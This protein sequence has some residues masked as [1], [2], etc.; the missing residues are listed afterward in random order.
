MDKI[1]SGHTGN[2]FLKQLTFVTSS[3]MVV[4]QLQCGQSL[5]D[6]HKKQEDHV[7]DHQPF[8]ATC[9]T[10]DGSYVQ[11]TERHLDT[12][13]KDHLPR[14]INDKGEPSSI[15]KHPLNCQ[16][17]KGSDHSSFFQ[18][19]PFLY[20]LSYLRSLFR[21]TVSSPPSASRS[22]DLC[23]REFEP[24]S[25]GNQCFTFQSAVQA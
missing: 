9:L 1:T 20:F 21:S 17:F 4:E 2:R 23:F 8:E 3:D 19:Y 22:D 12:R 14:W 5:E 25:I 7:L 13:I 6:H 10:D 24:Q 18:H 11:R 16:R 15:W